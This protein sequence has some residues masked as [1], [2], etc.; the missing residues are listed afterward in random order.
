[1]AKTPLK[2]QSRKLAKPDVSHFHNPY[3]GV[4]GAWQLTETV[5]T[6]LDRLPPA[7]TDDTEVGPWIFICN[8]YIDRKSKRLAQNQN[9]KGCED[10]APEEEGAN[11][12]LFVEGGME[13][14]HLVTE[15]HDKVNQAPMLAPMRTREKSKASI[16]ASRDIL[17]LAHAMH[18]RAG[19]WML[20]CTAQTVNEVWDVV[21][22]ATA[23]NEL[24]I[25]AKVATRS[26][27]D[28]R[29]ERLICVYTADFH[30][31]DDVER[32]ALKLKQLGLVEG[33]GKKPLYYKPGLSLPKSHCRRK[34]LISFRCLYLLGNRFWQRMGCQGIYLQY[35]GHAWEHVMIW[36]IGHPRFISSFSIVS[37]YPSTAIPLLL[38]DLHFS[39]DGPRLLG[40][41]SAP[42]LK[43]STG[44]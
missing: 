4:K 30:D 41:L 39:L 23:S 32:V 26:Q 34:R 1:M 37:R 17:A 33:R 22:K 28:P 27:I 25:A 7:T 44:R 12:A 15:F 3:A 10:E 6:F 29:P 19:K 21:A 38:L 18:V 42:A 13:R 31:K 35:Q 20:F 36:D 14:L 40:E 43:T 2:I 16:D 9:I 24:G 8:P 5:D 11:L